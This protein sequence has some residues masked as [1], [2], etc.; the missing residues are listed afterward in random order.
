M[1]HTYPRPKNY[2][3]FL[4]T[5]PKQHKMKRTN[6]IKDLHTAILTG[7]TGCGK[8]HLVL[9]LIGKGYNKKFDYIIIIFSTLR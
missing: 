5:V 2:L 8:T 6:Y 4:E 3:P 1:S 7:P 9:E